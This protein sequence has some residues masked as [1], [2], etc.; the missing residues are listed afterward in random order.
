MFFNIPREEMKALCCCLSLMVVSF[1][2]FFFIP[3]SNFIPWLL[4]GKTP[5]GVERG[6]VVI[7]SAAS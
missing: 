7:A 5:K 4:L 2:S 3:V 1:V 6:E